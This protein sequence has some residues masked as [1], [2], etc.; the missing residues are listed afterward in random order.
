MANSYFDPFF[1]ALGAAGISFS[2]DDLKVVLTDSGYTFSAAHQNLSDIPA[3]ARVATSGNLGGKTYS[4]GLFDADDVTFA[5]VAAGDTVTGVALYKDTGSAATSTL[6][7]F[8][9][10]D[11]GGAISI[12][13]NG[14]DINLTWDSGADRILNLNT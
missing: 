8:W 1:T 7:A 11:T 2:A 4:E 14:G 12:P 9:D 3:G 6:I 13:T 5:A 10:T